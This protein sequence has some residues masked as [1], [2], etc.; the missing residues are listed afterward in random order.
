MEYELGPKLV[1][2]RERQFLVGLLG[3]IS[4]IFPQTAQ[5]NKGYKRQWCESFHI[6]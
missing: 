4:Q 6:Y 5:G 1:T 2:I 3:Q